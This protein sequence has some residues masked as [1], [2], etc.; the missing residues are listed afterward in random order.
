MSAWIPIAF[1]IFAVGGPIW[2][3]Y[4]GDAG[5]AAWASLFLGIILALVVWI[6]WLAAR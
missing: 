2:L 4:R 3:G 6:V 1:T 5:P